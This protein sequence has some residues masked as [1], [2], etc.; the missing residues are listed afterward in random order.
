MATEAAEVL[1]S[2]GAN[3]SLLDLENDTIP[4]S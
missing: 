3:V 4:L 1:L 2:Y